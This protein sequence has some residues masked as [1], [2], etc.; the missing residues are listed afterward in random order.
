MVPD[1]PPGLTEY[2]LTLSFVFVPITALIVT[3]APG[4]VPD[5]NKEIISFLVAVG[6]LSLSF[7]IVWVWSK[8]AER[9]PPS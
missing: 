3:I 1:V 7:L 5:E 2:A 4:I 6:E 9:R 8:I